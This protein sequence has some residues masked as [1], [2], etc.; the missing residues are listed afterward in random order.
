V[1]CALRAKSSSA[2]PVS[3]SQAEVGSGTGAAVTQMRSTVSSRPAVP[4][5]VELLA[6]DSH[7]ELTP[8]VKDDTVSLPGRTKPLPVSQ[9]R[10]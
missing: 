7:S 3:S 5:T 9:A 4:C 6:S 2:A 10:L 1:R 8:L